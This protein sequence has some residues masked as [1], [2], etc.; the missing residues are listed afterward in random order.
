MAKSG[1]KS[2]WQGQSGCFACAICGRK[3]RANNQVSGHLCGHCDDW[4][5][6]EN[7]LNDDGAHMTEKEKADSMAFILKN[8]LEAAKRG[9]NRQALGLPAVDASAGASA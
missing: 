6:A 4:T 7:S 5:M 1:F 2:G 3:T 8:K 9:G